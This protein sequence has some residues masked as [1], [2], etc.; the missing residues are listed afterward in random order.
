MNPPKK[1]VSKVKSSNRLKTMPSHNIIPAADFEFI[2]KIFKP[3]KS[4][5]SKSKTKL[6]SNR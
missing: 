4:A 1:Q 3:R 2:E 6:N 5:K